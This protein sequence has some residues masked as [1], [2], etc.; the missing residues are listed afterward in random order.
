MAAPRPA[1]LFGTSVYAL[2]D[3]LV[4]VGRCDPEASSRPEIDLAPFDPEHLVS[5]R[6][7]Q[8][9]CRAG[10]VT[11][12]DL[13]SSNGTFVDGELLPADVPRPLRDQQRVRFGHL[14]LLFAADVT[15]SVDAERATDPDT[16]VIESA[17]MEQLG[18]LLAASGEAPA[19]PSRVVVERVQRALQSDELAIVF[20]PVAGLRL[21]RVVGVEALTRIAIEPRRGPDVW[22]GEAFTVGLGVDL[23]LLAI[24]RAL[25][26]L[27]QLPAEVYLAFNTSPETVLS[28][29][30]TAVLEAAPLERLVVEVTEHAAVADYEA[31]RHALTPFRAGGLRLAIDD[32]GS[33]YA[34]MQHVLR[35]APDI[36]KLDVAL[37]RGIDVDRARRALAGSLVV[38]ADEMGARLVAEGI[39][40]PDEL[41]TLI[42][43]GVPYGQGFH[44][45]RPGPLPLP[46]NPL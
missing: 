9:E 29:D 28:D 44:L 41:S 45:A 23:E 18:E 13:G 7:A 20:Q 25:D 42:E 46:D 10:T 32:M 36:I 1:L 17:V 26:Q 31:L 38:F 11:V 14:T 2:T 15:G 30:F 40:T 3:G 35:L 37:V 5:R 22:F 12:R 43:L 6:H 4:M 8:L 21:R 24:S 19:S 16:Q 39:E 27:D 33:G 34:N